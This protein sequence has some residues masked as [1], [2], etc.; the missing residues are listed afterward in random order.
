[1]FKKQTIGEF[2]FGDG[3]FYKILEP[4]RYTFTVT[5][6]N[7]KQSSFTTKV[8]TQNGN[9]KPNYTKL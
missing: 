9:F 7:G 8:T 2:T 4:G 6:S 3:E 1:M 5:D